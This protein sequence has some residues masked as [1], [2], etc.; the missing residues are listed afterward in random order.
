M[1]TCTDAPGWAMVALFAAT[2][3]GIF[4]FAGRYRP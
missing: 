2:V 4:V 1:A 3:L